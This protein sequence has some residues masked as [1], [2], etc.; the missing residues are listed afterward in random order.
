MY[1][2]QA[3]SGDTVVLKFPKPGDKSE[4]RAFSADGDVN[5]YEYCNLHGFWKNAD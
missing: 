4:L 5:A 1:K 3:A 2:R